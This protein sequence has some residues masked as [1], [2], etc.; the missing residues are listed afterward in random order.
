M[1]ITINPGTGPVE[2][3]TLEN[4]K[5]NMDAFAADLV[6]RGMYVTGLTRREDADDDGRYGYLLTMGDARKIEIDMPGLPLDQ[7][8]YMDTEGQDIWDF[9]RLYVDGSS[10]IWMFALGQ[11]EPPEGYVAPDRSGPQPYEIDPDD[12][13]DPDDDNP[14]SEKCGDPDCAC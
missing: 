7:V 14:T 4:A 3:A 11:C 10:W 2:G 8:R 1:T 5:A 13:A 9:P 6:E 12:A